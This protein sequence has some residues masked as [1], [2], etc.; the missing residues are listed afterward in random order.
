MWN[1]SSLQ[2]FS[3][4]ISTA[5]LF[6][7]PTIH[8]VRVLFLSPVH[9]FWA[10]SAFQWSPINYYH[11]SILESVNGLPSISTYF[12]VWFLI[13]IWISLW[14]SVLHCKNAFTILIS[15]CDLI[16]LYEEYL[17]PFIDIDLIGLGWAT[18]TVGFS[19]HKMISIHNQCL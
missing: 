8:Q 10:P 14:V 13:K 12:Q 5:T 3:C 2:T 1:K 7:G 15:N 16:S 19:T 4:F 18:G 17:W 6:Q 9:L 11:I